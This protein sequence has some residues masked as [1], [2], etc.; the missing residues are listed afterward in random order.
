MPTP[1]RCSLSALFGPILGGPEDRPRHDPTPVRRW[2]GPIGTDVA[3]GVAPSPPA[4]GESRLLPPPSLW[5]P[6]AHGARALA[7][8]ASVVRCT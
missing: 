3:A 1:P 2:P 4:R 8:A 5:L 7:R 6:S